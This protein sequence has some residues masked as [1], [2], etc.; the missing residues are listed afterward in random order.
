MAAT[1]TWDRLRELARVSGART[2]A[3]SASISTSIRATPPPPATRRR[4]STR[5]STRPSA[6]SGAAGQSS[7]TSRGRAAKADFERIRDLLRA[8]SST[9]TAPTA[10]PSSSPWLDNVW[11]PLALIE[12]VPDLRQGRARASTSRRSCRSSAEAR[13]RSSPSSSR[14]RGDIYR[15]HDGRLE[16]ARRPLRRA[17]W[18]A[19]PGR[20]VAVALS[21]GTSRSS[22]TT[23]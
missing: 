8:A 5:S 17:A 4:G 15:L 9:A 21:S 3:R 10:S 23:T 18:P 1:V 16:E 13:A 11:R 7:P 22:C 20:L 19:R 12:R 6:R 14:E 2:A